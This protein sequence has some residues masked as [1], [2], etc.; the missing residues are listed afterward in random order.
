MV[1]VLARTGYEFEREFC[2][3]ASVDVDPRFRLTSVRNLR[4]GI[5]RVKGWQKY[6]GWDPSAPRTEL[7]ACLFNQVIQR[8]RRGDRK[9]RLY[10][11]VG[12]RLDLMG[13]DCFF[14]HRHRLVTIDL[15]V[16]PSKHRS[17]ADLIL[18]PQHFRDG[19]YA[20]IGDNIAKKLMQ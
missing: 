18:R 14:E 10:I 19:E 1:Q 20:V 13:V 2:G 12:T 5:T 9:L 7:S 8:F 4:T 17:A 6:L 15:T 16:N 3:I 11:S